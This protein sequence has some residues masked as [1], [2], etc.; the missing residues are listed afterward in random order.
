MEQ[1]M[2]LGLSLAIAGGGLAAVMAGIGSIIGIGMT[3]QA[4][5]G[6]LRED[7][8]KF[9][10]LFL[11]VVLPGTQGFYGFI[12]AFLVMIKLGLLGEA[13]VEP[14][15]TQGIEIFFA[16]L[17]MAV[18]GL[19]SA[20]H[21]GRVC[22]AGVHVVAKHADQ[23]MKAVIFAAMVETYAVLGLLTTFFMLNGIRIG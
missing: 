3:G 12:A 17:P 16:C 20:I 10:P 18:T 7:P 6:V 4:A 8:D 21:Q 5:A 13:V 9:G 15:I 1:G 23:A 2:H 19:V 11:L 22:T 14:T